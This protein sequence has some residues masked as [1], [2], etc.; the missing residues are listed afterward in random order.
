MV[1]DAVAVVPKGSSAGSTTPSNID[2]EM[3]FIG[4]EGS[5]QDRRANSWR[6]DMDINGFGY[7]M[8]QEYNMEIPGLSV[9]DE[10]LLYRQQAVNSLSVADNRR[11]GYGG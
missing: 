6:G 1:S 4:G 11:I 8:L 9:Q 5:I 10:E 2:R 7:S 3:A